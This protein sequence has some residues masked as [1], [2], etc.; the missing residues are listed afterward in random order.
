MRELPERGMSDA[1]IRLEQVGVAD[2][3]HVGRAQGVVVRR[4][5]RRQQHVRLA[6]AILHGGGNLLQGFDAGQHTHLG[7]RRTGDESDK[8]HKESGHD[9]Y[10]TRQ[11]QV[12]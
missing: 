4:S 5:A 3:A 12:T 9:E 8:K 7:L 11:K 2:L 6:H 1:L 10:S